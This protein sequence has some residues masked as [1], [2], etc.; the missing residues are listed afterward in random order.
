MQVKKAMPAKNLLMT[1]PP[2]TLQD[3]YCTLALVGS[4]ELTSRE[5]T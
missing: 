2:I 3:E 4:A 1:Y 5:I